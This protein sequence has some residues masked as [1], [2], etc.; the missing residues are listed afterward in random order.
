MNLRALG[1]AAVAATLLIGLVPSGAYAD[2]DPTVSSTPTSTPAETPAPVDTPAPAETPA[3]VE[4]PTPAPSTPA[5][6]TDAEPLAISLDQPATSW[7]DR[8]LTFTGK[9]NNGAVGWYI[10]LWQALPSGWTLRG[11]T[12]STTGGAYKLTYTAP[13]AIHTTFRVAIG[14][15]FYG[16]PAISPAVIGTA[17]DR[18]IVI[19]TPAASYV[20]L[21]GVAATGHITPA[22]PGLEV[23][24]QDPV[25]SGQWRWLTSVKV[26]AKGN[27]R[28]KIPDNFPHTRTVRVVSRGVPAA[29]VEVSASA[30]Y[31]IKAA[32]NPKVYAVG[33]DA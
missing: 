7:E 31:V 33:R 4:T 10:T 26:D 9:L 19:D 18:K 8:P 1:T 5:R 16:A 25:G 28:L 14:P 6:T 17:Q 32:L 2:P 12:K 21:G 3:P 13:S 30:R 22:E 11:N 20:T 23:V 24:L 29:A 15:A 27:F